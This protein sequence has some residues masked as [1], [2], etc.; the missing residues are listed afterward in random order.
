M[1]FYTTEYIE[2]YLCPDLVPS[3]AIEM[4]T[5]GDVLHHTQTY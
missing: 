1:Y 2:V 4:F 5:T 3:V